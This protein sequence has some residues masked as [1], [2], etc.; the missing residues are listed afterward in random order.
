MSSAD[1]HGNFLWHE[2]A[3]T[4]PGAAGAFYSRVLGWKTQAWDKDPSYTV[5]STARGPAGGMMRLPAEAQAN[6]AAP[7][8]L[9]YVAVPDVNAAVATAQRLGGRVVK[10][11]SSLPDGARYAVLADPQSG[12][13]GICAPPSTSTGGGDEF[14]WHELATADHSA[15]FRFYGELFG[16]EQLGVH[17]MGAMG[18]Y[19][20]FGR[21][22]RQLGGMFS[23]P[24]TGS[25][26]RLYV[27]VSN[28]A[29]AA[30]AAAAAGG[31]VVN[32]PH[33]VP[34]GSWVAE[35]TDPQ[36]AAIAVNQPVTAAASAATPA[37]A[38]A[39]KPAKPAAPAASPAAAAKPQVAA[40]APRPAPTPPQAPRP[41][42]PP[43]PTHAPAPSQAPRPAA[44][45]PPVQAPQVR[46][47]SAAAP[48]AARPAPAAP[49]SAVSAAAGSTP[50]PAP[51]RT[52][53]AAAPAKPQAPA[54]KAGK[55]A[56][57]KVA[58]KAAPRRAA[59]AKKRKKTAAHKRSA[60]RRGAAKRGT[61]RR[62]ATKRRATSRVAG[63]RKSARRAA[64]RARKKVAKRPARRAVRRRK[65]ARRG[66][67]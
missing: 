63:R 9:A 67:R 42:S 32:G 33:Q 59:A 31:R 10:P 55:A 58:R 62:S 17:D 1:V 41:A 46:P 11:A 50:K 44:P 65:S 14:V 57:R 23:R 35:L 49:P 47:A 22:G 13:F 30:E 52:A 36:G 37:A 28:A 66:R 18:P 19:L 34:G 8:W 54:R 16:W 21:H 39:P 38:A 12:V 64:S 15:A 2:L 5:L 27:R 48:A 60:A 25:H 6:G 4:D 20:L 24:S 45:R 7:G 43:A 53:A 26:W 40:P 51:T 61:A 3:T 56:A 29:K